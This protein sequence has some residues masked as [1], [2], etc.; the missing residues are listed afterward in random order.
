M[1]PYRVHIVHVSFANAF[2]SLTITASEHKGHNWHSFD[3]HRWVPELLSLALRHRHLLWPTVHRHL[4]CDRYRHDEVLGVLGYLQVHCARRNRWNARYST[5]CYK[6]VALSRIDRCFLDRQQFQISM[7]NYLLA[8]VRRPMHS[9]SL[10]PHRD[11]EAVI[12]RFLDTDRPGL[13][14]C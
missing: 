14:H 5:G 12:Q 1:A 8:R 13:I 4:G 11:P 2:T 9:Q 3:L 10:L 7:N 6:S